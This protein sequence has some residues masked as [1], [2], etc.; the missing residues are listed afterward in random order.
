MPGMW[1]A[2]G[3][4]W[5]TPPAAAVAAALVPTR[6][7]DRALRALPRGRPRREGAIS[8]MEVASVTRVRGARV[9]AVAA[10]TAIG[11]CAGA[12]LIVT[13]LRLVNVRGVYQHLVHL[14]VDLM[15]LCGL[16]FLGAY[17]VRAL[18]WRCLLRPCEV[19]IWRAISIYQ[20]ATFLNWMLPVRGGELAKSLLLR[21]LNGIPVS[22]SLATVS[23]D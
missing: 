5:H 4:R 14:R 11:L 13:F 10:R 1:C 9:R 22:R 17:V 23:M 3:A 21:R 18:R 2:S 20:V 15:L 12:I 7:P 19:S 8:P 6:E 16:A